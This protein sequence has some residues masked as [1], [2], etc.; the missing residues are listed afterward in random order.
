MKKYLA[1]VLFAFMMQCA[2]GSCATFF[3]GP[4]CKKNKPTMCGGKHW[5][6]KGNKN[7]KKKNQNNAPAAD[8]AAE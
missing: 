5:A 1:V 3:H 4:C 8:A 7:W 2:Y 6:K